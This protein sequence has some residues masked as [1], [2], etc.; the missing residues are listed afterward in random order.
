MMNEMIFS[1]LILASGM[2]GFYLQMVRN[3]RREEFA[4]MEKLAL[5]RLAEAMNAPTSRMQSSRA[6]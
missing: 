3:K 4:H 2:A 6:A 5:V 1:L